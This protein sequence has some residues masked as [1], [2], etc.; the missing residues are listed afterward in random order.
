MHAKETMKG[1]CVHEMISEKN[2]A[3]QLCP[4]VNSDKVTENASATV[5]EKLPELIENV[6]SAPSQQVESQHSDK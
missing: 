5:Q 4:K 3:P 6:T 2:S 1:L